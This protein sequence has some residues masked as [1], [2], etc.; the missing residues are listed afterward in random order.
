MEQKKKKKHMSIKVTILFIVILLLIFGIYYIMRKLNSNGY[1]LEQ[2]GYK[3]N[4]ISVITTNNTYLDYALNNNYNEKLVE[5]INNESFK[6][7]F[8]DSYLSYYQNN[9]NVPISDIIYLVNNDINYE[10]SETLMNF[11]KEKYFLKTRIERYLNYLE[12]HNDLS[13]KE[14]V[15]RVNSDIDYDFYTNIEDTDM[16]Y[17]ELIICNKHYKLDSTYTP[18]NLVTIE[19]KYAKSYLGQVDSTTYEAY[20][21]M[22]NK[23]A[24]EN[25]HLLIQ[26]PYRSYVS[27]DSIYNGYVK[28]D[29]KSLADTYSARPG[30][31]EHQTGLAIDFATN[32]TTGLSNS[33]FGVTNEFKWLQDHAHEYGFILR[34]PKGE[35]YITGYMYESWHYRYVGVD[36][37]TTIHN[38]NITYEEYFTYYVLKK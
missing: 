31:S 17:N 11:T 16:S 18:N 3:N 15:K 23:M 25:L 19:N 6:I 12:S 1:K 4:E 14:V 13:Y 32:K 24:E 5:F 26:S 36:V 10:Y 8:F 9:H 33:E 28:K 29:G 34:Y 35:E 22:A 7:E 2:I 37:A 30:H 27:Q 21:K 20:K 38:E